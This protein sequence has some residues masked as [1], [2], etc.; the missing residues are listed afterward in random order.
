MHVFLQSLCLEPV[1]NVRRG[2]L[3]PYKRVCMSQLSGTWH[4]YP[5]SCNVYIK[6]NFRFRLSES[7]QCFHI[8]SLLA[9]AYL[10]PV[11]WKHL[12]AHVADISGSLSSDSQ[13]VEGPGWR[14]CVRHCQMDYRHHITTGPH[15]GIVSR[16]RGRPRGDLGPQVYDW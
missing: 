3:Q 5:N 4:V 6:V 9:M 14:S 10:K 7:F 2:L 11:S 13:R 15:L 12:F 8:Y 1:G 16:W